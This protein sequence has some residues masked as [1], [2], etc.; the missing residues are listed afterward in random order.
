M[1]FSLRAFSSASRAEMALPRLL[2]LAWEEASMSAYLIEARALVGRA[3]FGVRRP[4]A[5]GWACLSILGRD[6]RGSM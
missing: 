5:V 6:L 3:V 1:S 4:L 2:A